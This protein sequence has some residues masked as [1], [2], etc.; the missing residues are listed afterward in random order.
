MEEMKIIETIRS[1]QHYNSLIGFFYRDQ[2]I[3]D[4][5]N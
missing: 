5:T 3:Y 4:G 1:D 2:I